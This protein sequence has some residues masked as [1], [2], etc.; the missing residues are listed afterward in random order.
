[1]ELRRADSGPDLWPAVEAAQYARLVKHEPPA[2]DAEAASIQAVVDLFAACAEQWERQ[3][4]ADQAITLEQLDGQMA[5]LRAL[6]LYVHWAVTKRRFDSAEGA[7]VDLPVAVVT[8][9]HRDEPTITAALPDAIDA[10]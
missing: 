5:A 1:M 10:G 2:T 6:G 4:A 7:P 8:V 3:S 9:T